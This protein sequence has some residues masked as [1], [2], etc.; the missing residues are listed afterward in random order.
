MF[1]ADVMHAFLNLQEPDVGD[2]RA[3]DEVEDSDSDGEVC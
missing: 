2:K 3:H 1:K